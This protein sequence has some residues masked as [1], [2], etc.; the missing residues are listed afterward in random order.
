MSE[1]RPKKSQTYEVMLKVS[2]YLE[3]HYQGKAVKTEISQ[4]LDPTPSK[5]SSVHKKTIGSATFSDT[6]F[7]ESIRLF[8]KNNSEWKR[9]G[10][11]LVKAGQEVEAKVD[12]ID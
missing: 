8:L 12:L 10:Q 4:P 11:A 6:L 7:R 3:T 1:N 5:R 9:Q 2:R